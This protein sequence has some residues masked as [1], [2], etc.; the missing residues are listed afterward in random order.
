MYVEHYRGHPQTCQH[1]YR[2]WKPWAV[3]FYDF[4]TAEK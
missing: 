2:P 1:E 4:H 3:I